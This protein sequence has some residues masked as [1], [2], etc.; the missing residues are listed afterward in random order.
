MVILAPHIV[1]FPVTDGIF[2]VGRLATR[3]KALEGANQIGSWH[4]G[5]W[6]DH[7]HTTIRIQFDNNEDARV[8]TLSLLV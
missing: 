1:T 7:T 8:A 3:L 2:E 4:V 6:I 5:R